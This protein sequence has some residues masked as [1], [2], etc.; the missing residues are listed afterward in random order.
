MIGRISTPG[1]VHVDQ[2]EADALLLL[3]FAVRAHQAEDHVGVL[4]QRGPGLLAVDDVVVA[5]GVDAAHGGGLDRR[6]VGAG[7]RLGVALAPPVRPSRM[8][9]SQCCFCSSLPYLISTG[10]SMLTPNGT[11]RGAC[12]SA[13]SFSKMNF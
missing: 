2:Q 5:A 8:R 13:H 11:M 1:D 9:G 7:A 6:Q 4:A 3:G 10:P 12:A